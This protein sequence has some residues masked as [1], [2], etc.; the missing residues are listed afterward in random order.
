MSSPDAPSASVP[1]QTRDRAVLE[2]Q[3]GRPLRAPACVTK[4]CAFDLPVVITVPPVLEH[5][6]PFPTRYW[7]ACPLAHRRI[8]RIEAA[9]GVRDVDARCAQ[10]VELREAVERAHRRYAQERDALVPQ[11]SKLKPTGGV[12]GS[13]GGIK[14][15]HAHYADFAAGNDNPVGAWVDGQ[16]GSLNCAAPCVVEPSVLEPSVLEPSVVEPSVVDAPDAQG[17]RARPQRNVQWT[18]PPQND[19]ESR[20]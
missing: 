17:E 12:G 7:L 3:I 19:N 4:R 18:E 15:L 10:D 13:T 2:I 1:D 9:G 5:G 14:C 11:G 16:I 20:D 6:E 8:A